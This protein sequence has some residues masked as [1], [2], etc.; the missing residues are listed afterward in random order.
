VRIT[1][2]LWNGDIGGAERVTVNLAR[3]LTELGY[4]THILFVRCPDLLEPSLRRFDIP[5]TALN[6]PRGRAVVLRPRLLA[7]ALADVATDVVISV[8]VGYLGAAARAG[9]FRGPILGIEHGRLLRIREQPPLKLAGEWIG[10]L[11]GVLTHDAEIAVSRF[12]VDVASSVAHPQIAYIPHGVD[13]PKVATA[14]PSRPELIIGYAGRLHPGKGIDTLLRALARLRRTD[15]ELGFALRICG[16]GPMRGAWAELAETLGLS[17]QVSFLGWTDD[18][19][20]HWASCHVAVAPN[21]ELS[22][23]FGM[24]T[25]EAMAAGRPTVVSDRGG[26]AELVVPGITGTVVPAGNEAELAGA[27]RTYAY[28]RRRV[29]SE[30][31]A[32]RQRAITTYSLDRMAQSYATLSSRLLQEAQARTSPPWRSRQ[33]SSTAGARV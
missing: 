30:G 29:E 21:D 15:P 20:R 18:V 12:M 5:F 25:V 22:E 3:M 19:M 31:Q 17:E 2:L 11:S 9:G 33:R 23:S 14:L 7:A 1:F 28:D 6:L 27:I 10:R 4:P 16:D 24:S 13:P 32:A 26:L 8:S